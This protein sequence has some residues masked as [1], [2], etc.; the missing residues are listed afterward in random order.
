SSI[1]RCAVIA[2]VS[3]TIYTIN[4][5]VLLSG[6][7]NCGDRKS[8]GLQFEIPSS[9]LRCAVIATVSETIYTINKRV[10]LS[11]PSNCGCLCGY[12]FSIRDSFFDTT[13]CS[14][15]HSFRDHLHHQQTSASL[16]T[17]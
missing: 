4:K 17:I 2:T 10:L 8:V 1:L 13:L 11:G 3:E 5:R 14:N 12:A 9:I 7:S 6:P 15:C 16:W